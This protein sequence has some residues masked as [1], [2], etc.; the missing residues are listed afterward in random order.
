MKS[1]IHVNACTFTWSVLHGQY[2][3]VWTAW[4]VQTSIYY[5]GI[6]NSATEVY[7]YA[8]HNIPIY[9]KL[10]HKELEKVTEIRFFIVKIYL[11]VE[12]VLKL[13]S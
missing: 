9:F 2:I 1:S 12:K 11:R 8:L 7:N 5:P 10:H 6:H 3:L 4:A 13:L